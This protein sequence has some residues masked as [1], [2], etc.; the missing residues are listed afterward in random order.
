MASALSTAGYA[1]TC[2]LTTEQCQVLGRINLGQLG[3]NS[4]AGSSIA[5][6]VS[7]LS[8]GVSA[9]TAGGDRTCALTVAGGVKA[10]V[11][12]ARKRTGG[13]E[14]VEQW[15]PRYRCWLGSKPLTWVTLVR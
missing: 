13:C 10:G 8:S 7:S 12:S 9:I 1:H 4:T 3:N 14:W 5:V 11:N 2:A 6:D 15:R